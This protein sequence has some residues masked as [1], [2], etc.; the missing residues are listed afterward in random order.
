MRSE[1]AEGLRYVGRHPFLRSIAATTATSNLCSNIV[2]AI[3]ILYLVRELSFTP[4]LLGLAFSI[5]SVGFLIGALLANR[6]A[7]RFG[8]GPTIV[9]SAFASGPSAL[10]VAIAPPNLALPLVA[11]SIFLG[12]L[13]GAIYNINQV[14]LRQAITPERMQG[15]MNATMR[16]IVWGTIP[17]GSTL[18][19][20]LGGVIGLHETIWVGAIGG[21]FVFLPALLSP[22]RSLQQIPDAEPEAEVVASG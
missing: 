9:G 22:V 20:I 5:G 16:F 14:S 6:V 8:V 12:G 10:L 4:E 21:C 13:G 18:G 15:R 11:A 17:I 1:I 2:F 3:L 7:V 19:G